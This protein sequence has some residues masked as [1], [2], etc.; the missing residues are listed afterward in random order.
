MEIIFKNTDLEDLEKTI[1]LCNLCFH[2][3]T[4]YEY[5]KKIFLEQAS[6]SNSI[7]IN[8]VCNGEVIAHA[9]LT[10]IK[11][12]YDPMKTYGILNH[13]C[14]RPDMRR[15]HIATHLLDV[16]FKVAKEKDCECVELWSKNFRIEAHACYKKYGFVLEEAGFFSKEVK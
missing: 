9:K 10:I 4:S 3:K 11:T 14:V 2:E 6:D 8:G 13:V 16:I 5:A 1:D 15:H 7:Y 12:I